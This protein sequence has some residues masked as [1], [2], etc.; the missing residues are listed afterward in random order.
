MKPDKF[1]EAIRR[2][3][4]GIQ[5]G[6]QDEDWAKFKAFKTTQAPTSFVQRFGRSMW[7]TAA[8][9]AAAVVV[10]ANVYQYRQNRTLD[11][12]VAQLKQQL[13][14]KQTPPVRIST[15]VDTV[16]I[17]KYIPVETLHPQPDA[18][19]QTLP[20]SNKNELSAPKNAAEDAVSVSE[21]LK[22][23]GK[24]IRKNPNERIS[25]AFERPDSSEPETA[26]I[27]ET[28]NPT[29]PSAS[30]KNKLF[31][32]KVKKE[33]STV[34]KETE[35]KNIRI[36]SA[37]KDYASQENV[38]STKTVSESSQSEIEKE[39][40]TGTV[41]AAL[42]NTPP[43][44][45]HVVALMEPNPLAELE[46]VPPAEVQVKRYAY[47]TLQS[48]TAQSTAAGEA[49]T[50]SPPPP[51]ISVKNIRF[52]AGG[53][54]NIGDKY[55]GYNLMSSILL[56][57]YWS[58]DVG[59]GKAKITGP[60]YFT[61]AVFNTKTGRPFQAWH[62]EDN[63]RPPLM[64]PQIFDIKT[65]VTLVRMPVSLTYRWPIKENFTL[66]FSGGTNINLSAQQCYRFSYKE[67][68]GNFEEK[69][70]NFNIKPAVSND[71][72][73]A[74]GVEKQWRSIVFQAEAYAAPYLQKPAYLTDNRN[75]GV[76]FKILYQF[77]KN[78]I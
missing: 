2:K 21:G 60:E 62:K 52:R 42:A 15:R 33:T 20:Q 39:A 57:K 44:N 25:E 49:N 47:A 6:F 78:P 66:L 22:N 54:L 61:D 74:A 77:G 50:T 63:V 17:T 70:G 28:D 73:I 9:V 67:R 4:E 16:Y 38:G 27:K 58:L 30:E 29:E 36:S 12:Q 26:G 35:G 65:D 46:G 43:A 64:P 53:G 7:Y 69:E 32:P 5:P 10:F 71:I 45:R 40:I 68:N 75:L 3:L 34:Q 23:V 19:A 37:Q 13:D 18:Y 41:N 1:D 11:Q 8:S 55:T 51:S 56:G 31:S 72:M 48:K 59:I 76:R 14:Q 24:I